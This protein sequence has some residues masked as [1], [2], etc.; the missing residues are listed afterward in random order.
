MNEIDGIP[1]GDC[2]F[3][4]VLKSLE[5]QYTTQPILEPDDDLRKA[6]TMEELRQSAHNHIHKLF[7]KR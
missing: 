3:Q 4:L 7:A 2:M 6:I 5:R 1:L